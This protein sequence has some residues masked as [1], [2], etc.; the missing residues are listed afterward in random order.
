MTLQ[1]LKLHINYWIFFLFF[2][3]A[4][5]ASSQ[6][7]D[8]IAVTGK[9]IASDRSEA[10]SRALIEAVGKVNPTAVSAIDQVA[11]SS[12]KKISKIDGVASTD[13][14]RTT[15][16]DRE[17]SQATKGVVKSWNIVSE[18]L[19]AQSQ[20]VVIVAAEVFRLKDSPQLSRKRVSI[21]PGENIDKNL[22]IILSTAVS[23]SLTKSRK[24]AVL[25]DN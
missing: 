17:F 15:E 14:V 11:K 13:S 22:N 16:I 19:N 1:R 5:H 21:I 24:F 9:G 4:G 3:T 7:V 2:L 12:R 23:E 8:T 18:S 20:F 25:Q 6:P 10:V